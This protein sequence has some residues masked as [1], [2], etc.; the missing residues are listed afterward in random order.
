MTLYEFFN[1]KFL[2]INYEIIDKIWVKNIE[3]CSYV[4]L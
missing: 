3:T 2:V 4:Y 1:N